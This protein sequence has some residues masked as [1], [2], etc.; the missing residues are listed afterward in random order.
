MLN[1]VMNHPKDIQIRRSLRPAR[2]QR[3]Q[4]DNRNNQPSHIPT[5]PRVGPQGKWAL[6]H[7]GGRKSAE[8]VSWGEWLL[9]SVCG[10]D[11]LADSRPVGGG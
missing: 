6:F 2:Y 8:Y 7:F 1:R 4:P 9:G 11:Y 10:K 5:F 3:Q